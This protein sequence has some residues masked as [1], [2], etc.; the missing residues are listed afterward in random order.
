MLGAH[1]AV[2]PR[3]GSRN[4]HIGTVV[5][6]G[7]SSIVKLNCELRQHCQRGHPDSENISEND[8]TMILTL[9]V[10]SGCPALPSIAVRVLA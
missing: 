2:T 10:L 8:M 6:A 7:H 5:L 9:L 4:G 1:A 3:K